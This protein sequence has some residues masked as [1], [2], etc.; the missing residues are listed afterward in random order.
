[1]I[2]EI[3]WATTAKIPLEEAKQYLDR[4]ATELNVNF[5][6][7]DKGCLIYQFPFRQIEPS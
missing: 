3:G 7:T 6:T 1:M 4:K 2:T 5:D